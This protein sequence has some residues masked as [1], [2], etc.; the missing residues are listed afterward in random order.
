M[1]QDASNEPPSTQMT[2]KF[3]RNRARVQP[4]PKACKSPKRIPPTGQVYPP[5]AQLAN[6][7]SIFKVAPPSGTSSTG[8]GITLTSIGG[9]AYT[10]SLI[11]N[12]GRT[13]TFSV[14][15]TV[16]SPITVAV[17]IAAFG[18][19]SPELTATAAA[20]PGTLP[21]GPI[22]M[23]YALSSGLSGSGNCTLTLT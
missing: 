4:T 11:D 12:Q 7:W 15:I 21:Y 13:C 6:T 18:D 14:S 23:A 5:T 10:G 22:M 16:G 1:T 17:D 8:T 9:G 3:S 19:V 20:W 2:T